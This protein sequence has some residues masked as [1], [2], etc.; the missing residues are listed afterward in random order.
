MTGLPA[1][2][3]AIASSLCCLALL[4]G[5]GPAASAQASTAGGSAGVPQPII[6]KARSGPCVE[7]PAVMRRDHPD[8]LG[9]QRDRTMREGIRT[10]RH[11]LKQ[12]IAC[13]ANANT[14]SV[15]GEHGFCQSCHDYVSVRIDC[16][17]CHSAKPKLSYG[18][19]Q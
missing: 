13:H 16:F 6:E 12:C 4:W 10:P 15:I 9:H 17:R 1:A 18:A 14:D 8:L 11:S 7:D 5:A 3:R 2:R 19:K